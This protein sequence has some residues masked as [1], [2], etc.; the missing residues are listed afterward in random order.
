MLT[1]TQLRKL[2]RAHNILSKI[3]IPKGASADDMVKLIESNGYLVNHEKQKIEQKVKRGKQITLKQAEEITKP[4]PK[5]ALQKQK[6]QEKK[7]EK[8]MEQKKKDRAIRKTAVSEE[9]KRQEKK[10]PKP[11]PKPKT[12]TISTQ[13]DSPPPPKKKVEPPKKKV[14]SLADPNIKEGVP[15]VKDLKNVVKD[16]KTIKAGD[17]IR[18][19]G[20]DSRDSEYYEKR[21]T[22]TVKTIYKKNIKIQV[23]GSGTTLLA[24]PYEM[25][26]QKE[27]GTG[28]GQ[29]EREVHVAITSDGKYSKP[30]GKLTS[31]RNALIRAFDKIDVD[32]VFAS[33]FPDMDERI[34]KLKNQGRKIYKLNFINK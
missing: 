12:A 26:G 13:T 17:I 22:G 34:A 31:S 8:Q 1:K 24:P 19:F 11:A 10:K 16:R 14:N 4:K 23:K 27:D 30:D 9:K 3:T 29:K 6:A 20:D 2:I 7:A 18:G 32:V 28:R 21:L 15:K 5:T 33:G 25:I